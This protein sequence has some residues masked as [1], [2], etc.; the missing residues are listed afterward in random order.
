MESKLSSIQARSRNMSKPINRKDLRGQKLEE[1][2]KKANT[3]TERGKV[4]CFGLYQNNIKGTNDEIAE[5]CKKC[6]AYIDNEENF[7]KII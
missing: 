4:L 2:C 1:Y 3:T 5:C 7:K 6:K